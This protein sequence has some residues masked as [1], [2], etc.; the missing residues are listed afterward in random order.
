MVRAGATL[1]VAVSL[2]GSTAARPSEITPD[3]ARALAEDAAIFGFAIVEN[4]KALSVHAG[5]REPP[6]QAPLNTFG[7]TPKLFGPRDTAVVSASNDTLYSSAWLD[8]RAEPVVLQVPAVRNRYYAMQL[9]DLVTDN[10]AYVG[11]RT[12]GRR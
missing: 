1:L 11:T 8:L 4:Y 3:E 9:C 5:N 7:H 6:K 2:I 10:F 12:T